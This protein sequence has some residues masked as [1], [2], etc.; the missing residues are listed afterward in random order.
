MR[1]KNLLTIGLLVTISLFIGFKFSTKVE[2][3]ISCPEYM[4]DQECLDYLD[5]RLRELREDQSDI[6]DSLESE[7]YKQ[8]TLEEK[9]SYIATQ[10]SETEKVVEAIQ[11]EISENNT[12][13]AVLEEEIEDK[14]DRLALMKQE[15]SLLEDDVNKSVVEL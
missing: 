14:D 1:I 9:I 11:A 7:Q 15:I 5:E 6:Q 12:Q 4:S 10:V 3:E 13:I 8:K 2:A